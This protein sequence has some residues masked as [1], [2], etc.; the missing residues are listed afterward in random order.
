MTDFLD[1][2]ALDW[3]NGK[4]SIGEALKFAYARGYEQRDEE[5]Y[6]SD[7]EMGERSDD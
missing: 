2:L 7:R 5:A 3:A 4:V 1:Q 6:W